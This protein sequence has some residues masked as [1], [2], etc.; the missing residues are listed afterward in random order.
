MAD[1][2]LVKAV[3]I[4]KHHL[5]EVFKVSLEDVYLE[6]VDSIG[7]G[8]WQ[9]TLSYYEPR[10]RTPRTNSILQTFLGPSDY[11]KRYKI[12][13]L[14]RNGTPESIKKHEADR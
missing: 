5:S 14:K 3:V 7:G 12:V 10:V 11:V 2:D 6:E 9:I 1:I 13:Q 4:S 8:R